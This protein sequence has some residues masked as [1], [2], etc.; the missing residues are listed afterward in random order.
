MSFTPVATE[1]VSE[2][3]RA[4]LV[5]V[6]QTRALS[7]EM[8]EFRT[9]LVEQGVAEEVVKVLIGLL[10]AEEGARPEDGRAFLKAY[11]D[12]K[13]LDPF[14]AATPKVDIE[15]LIETNESLRAEHERLSSDVFELEQ[16][17]QG[18]QLDKWAAQLDALA[19]AYKVAGGEEDGESDGTFDAQALLAAAQAA[20]LAAAAEA[21]LPAPELEG[22]PLPPGAAP[23]EPLACSFGTLQEWALAEF[24]EA[25]P[26]QA[27]AEWGPSSLE[28]FVRALLPSFYA[29]A[30][31]ADGGGDAGAGAAGAIAGQPAKPNAAVLAAEAEAAAMRAVRLVERARAAAAEVAGSGAAE[32]SGEL[33]GGA[34][35]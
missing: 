2:E 33:D 3:Y 26:G 16:I 32:G 4:E 22:L 5:R 12:T 7:E 21:R 1:S 13:Q 35:E 19:R 23:P 11:F 8:G 29:K 6:R 20:A 17:W 27:Q 10:S 25:A 18:L 9:Y 34:A 28:V 15:E 30:D 14:V 31:Y 24:A